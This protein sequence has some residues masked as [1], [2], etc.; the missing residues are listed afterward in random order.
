MASYE[1]NLALPPELAAEQEAINRRRMIAQAMMQQA[2][3]PLI[4]AQGGRYV[5]PISPFQGIAKLAKSYLGAKGVKDSEEAGKSLA[6]RSR[7][8][9]QEEMARI[10]QAGVGSPEISQPPDAIGG[11][12][13]RAAIPGGRD[14]LMAAMAQSRYP[15]M[16]GMALQQQMKA[17]ERPHREDF[18]LGN[19]RYSADGRVIVTGEQK[20]D[21]AKY[22]IEDVSMGNGLWQQFR[23]NTDGTIDF[24]VP[25]G[26]PFSKRPT[27]SETNVIGSKADSK[28][29]EERMKSRAE[30]M[31]TLDKSAASAYNQIKSL[32][33]FVEYSKSG[34]QGSVQPIITQVE[35]FLSSF[36]YSSKNLKDVRGMEQAIGDI[37][38]TKMAEL[39]ARGLTDKDMKVLREALPRVATDQASRE[40][41]ASV[42]KKSL[43]GV[44]E[45][46]SNQREEESKI[47]PDLSGKIPE[48]AW[49][50]DYKKGLSADK[51]KPAISV[52]PGTIPE[53]VKQFLRR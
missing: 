30:S 45:E 40:N 36:G 11:G 50:K 26:K 27:A 23:K 52:S 24:K 25:I 42:L 38:S 8:A 9:R 35:N 39:G 3:E 46:Y 48:P 43:L 29:A 44:I 10:L 13:G 7:A 32:D 31:A 33:R 51:G 22:G 20:K 17:M 16:Q 21:E 12:P 19:T 15:D 34:S 37:L 18:T 5:V 53:S 2:Q 49:F 28:Y 6:E 47:Y 41:V 14:K 1:E 4:P